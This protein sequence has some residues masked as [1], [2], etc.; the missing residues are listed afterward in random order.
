MSVPVSAVTVQVTPSGH[1][2]P[3]SEADQGQA[4]NG[5]HPMAKALRHG[6]AGQS[7]DGRYCQGRRYVTDTRLERDERRFGPGPSPLPCDQ[8]DGHPMVGHD[9]MQD[10]HGGDCA[11]EQ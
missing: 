11:N 9:G 7:N 6:H 3:Q 8:G 1:G 5:V 4:G 2:N 10:T